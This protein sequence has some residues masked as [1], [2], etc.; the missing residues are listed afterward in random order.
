[1]ALLIL[2]HDEA[3]EWQRRID[4][5]RVGSFTMTVDYIESVYTNWRTPAEVQQR[6]W[7]AGF[8]N[9]QRERGLIFCHCVFGLTTLALGSAAALLQKSKD[10]SSIAAG[11]ALSGLVTF[12]IYLLSSRLFLDR[13]KERA[14]AWRKA[15]LLLTRQFEQVSA[16]S[17]L[18]RPTGV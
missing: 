16:T 8:A 4:P 2:L 3:E 12:L 13:H 7:A 17:R 18:E 14:N 1:M 6:M 10:P 5:E 9:Q 11:V 15:Y